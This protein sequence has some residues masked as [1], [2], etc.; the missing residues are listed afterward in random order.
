MLPNVLF[1]NAVGDIDIADILADYAKAKKKCEPW[2]DNIERWRN[3]YDFNHYADR[4]K[5]KPY[6][7]RFEDPTPTNVVDTAVGIIL[8]KGIEWKAQG[9]EPS[10]QEEEETSQIEKYLLGTIEVNAEREEMDLVYEAVFNLVRDGCAVLYSPWD[11]LLEDEFRSFV[12]VPSMEAEMGVEVK[13]ALLYNPLRLQVI[14]PMKTHWLPGGPKRW[15]MVFKVEEMTVY[16]VERTFGAETKH[17]ARTD[18]EKRELKGEL[19]DHWRWN[20]PEDGDWV[21]QRALMFDNDYIEGWELQDTDYP[22]LPYTIGFYKPVDRDDPENWS[23]SIIRPIET[24]VTSLENAINRRARQIAVISAL[25]MVIRA[26]QGRN[27]KLDPGLFNSVNI[28]PDE[29]ISFPK[30]TGNAP[31]VEQH[32]QYLRS[33]LQQAGFSEQDLTGGAASGYALSQIGDAN[34]IK[35]QQPVRH[36]GLL[37]SNWGR[38]VLRLTEAF[39]MGRVIRVYGTQKG[40]DFASQIVPMGFSDYL[41]RAKFKPEYPGDEVRNHAMASQI[42]GSVSMHTIMEKYLD[43]DQPDDE[44][45]RMIQEMAEMHPMVIEYQIRQELVEMAKNGDVAANMTLMAMQQGQSGNP[46]QAK[47]PPRGAPP[48]GTK[49]QTGQPTRQEQGGQPEG[50]SEGDFVDQAV[51]AMPMMSA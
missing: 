2:H 17:S 8:A 21:V 37:W 35:L 42:K 43:I 18:R 48:T 20:K 32:I 33:R 38:K 26:M 24:T 12:Q 44:K 50:Q 22:D 41:V 4:G 1:P 14:D 10:L 6:E 25:P 7:E 27:L 16:D 51:N 19:I 31:D 46:N 15:G 9:F 45:D 13:E 30:W 23:H 3:W 49:S 36:L 47:A 11:F 40:K 29:D 5:A 28:L 34:K 39:A